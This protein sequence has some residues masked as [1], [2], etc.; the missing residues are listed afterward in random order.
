M[1]LKAHQYR[2]IL[3]VSGR[4]RRTTLPQCNSPCTKD[5]IGKCL[6]TN[7]MH[8]S[9]DHE[10]PSSADIPCFKTSTLPQNENPQNKEKSLTHEEKGGETAF[11]SNS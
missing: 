1:E 3:K 7:C 4:F 9:V 5:K 11:L 2:H 8:D 6:S 10:K